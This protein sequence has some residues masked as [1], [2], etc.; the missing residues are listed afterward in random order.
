MTPLSPADLTAQMPV[1][2]Q[3]DRDAD[4]AVAALSERTHARHVAEGVAMVTFNRCEAATD[5]ILAL[6]VATLAD[7]AAQV[8]VVAFNIRRIREMSPDDDRMSEAA[9]MALHS[10][11]VPILVA[12]GLTLDPVTA[13]YFLPFASLLGVERA[14]A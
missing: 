11:L 10:A 2:I 5:L 3:A 9:E 13:S 6:P 8:M 12:S 1:L 7:A 14:G 4:N